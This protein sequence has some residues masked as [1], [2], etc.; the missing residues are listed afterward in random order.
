LVIR[1]PRWAAPFIRP[2]WNLR[3]LS[4]FGCSI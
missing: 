1:L 2:R 4:R 3:C